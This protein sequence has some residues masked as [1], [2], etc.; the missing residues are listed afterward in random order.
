M[1]YFKKAY[2]YKKITYHD[3]YPGIDLVYHFN[4][5]N[6]AGLNTTLI[7]HPG[8]DISVIRAKYNGD[9]KKN[10]AKWKGELTITQALME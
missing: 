5:S 3:I 4:K 7:V 1:V 2:L 8:A 9:I 10:A 6:K